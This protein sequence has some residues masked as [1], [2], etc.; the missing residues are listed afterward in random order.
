MFKK[1]LHW[2]GAAALTATSVLAGSF[3]LTKPAKAAPQITIGFVP[4]LASDPFFLSMQYGAQQEARKLGVHLIWQGALGTYSPSAQLPYVN[5]VLNQK[6]NAFIL[7]PTDAQALMPSVNRALALHIPV[8]TA[9]T[10]VAD[11]GVLTARITGDNIGGGA[12]AA[13]LLAKAV[14]SKGQVYIMNGLPGTTTDQLRVQ[15]F[16]DEIKRYKGVQYLGFQ[17][18]QDQPSHA[19]TV[20]QDLL[21]RYPHLG[22]IYCIDDETAIGVIR[23]LQNV[24]KL[25]QVKV[26]A[27]DAEPGEVAAL[28]SGQLVALIAQRPTVEGSMAVQIAYQAATGKAVSKGKSIIIPDVLI[29]QSN[30]ARNAQWFYRSKP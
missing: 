1:R 24:H 11:T 30:Q 19:A 14:G 9:D 15:G 7:V 29:T 18:S 22:G 25:G 3:G 21:L 2:W 16:T 13:D 6:P 27:Y 8:L 4:S 20:V 23:G 5:A 10:T 26:I 12:Q 28:K 17:F